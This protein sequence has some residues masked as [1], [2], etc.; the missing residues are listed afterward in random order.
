MNPPYGKETGRWLQKAVDELKAGRIETAVF[1]IPART[2]TRF[3]HDIV[4]RHAAAIYFVR[5][6]VTFSNPDGRDGQPAPFP[7]M[8]IVLERD[9]GPSPA[10]WAWVTKDPAQKVFE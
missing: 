8:V 3:F 2:D 6:R 9:A 4:M 7:S 1:L 10:L 5:G